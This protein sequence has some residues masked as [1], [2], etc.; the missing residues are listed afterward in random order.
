MNPRMIRAALNGVQ[1]RE[2]GRE[3]RE[4]SLGERVRERVSEVRQLEEWEV[5]SV[6][7]AIVETNPWHLQ[8]K[9]RTIF[10][11][12]RSAFYRGSARGAVWLSD[13]QIQVIYRSR[14]TSQ[15]IT[16]K[17]ARGS[18]YSVSDKLDFMTK[19]MNS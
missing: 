14:D 9:H 16:E 5:V 7:K 17:I 11:G 19:P 8:P 18:M 3:K 4:E 1:Q 10:E 13:R 2:F 15:R 6:Q 12:V